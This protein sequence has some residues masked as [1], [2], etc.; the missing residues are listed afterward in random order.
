[1]SIR[2]RERAGADSV[3]L[4]TLPCK[5]V[6]PAWYGHRRYRLNATCAM[7]C[8]LRK[9]ALIGAALC[10]LTRR[11]LP[12]S[13][14]ASQLREPQL[15]LPGWLALPCV[16]VASHACA[17]NRLRVGGRSRVAN[18]L[19]NDR[20]ADIGRDEQG[21][22]RAKAV[23]FLEQLVE[24]DDDDA[25]NKELQDDENGVARAE[26]AH[27]AVHARDDVCDLCK[28]RARREQEVVSVR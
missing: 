15:Q 2:E 26:L 18:A 13:P 25:R 3:A 11:A 17:W 8:A 28:P 19:P 4:Q 12:S 20:L 23:A 6:R 24:D 21:D 27:V 1:M 14:R 5:E 10:P 9:V 22:A 16:R 7:R